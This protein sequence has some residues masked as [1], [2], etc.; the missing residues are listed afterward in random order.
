MV[1]QHRNSNF[2]EDTRETDIDNK[3]LIVGAIKQFYLDLDEDN[4]F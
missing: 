2:N 1:F 3:F 4:L